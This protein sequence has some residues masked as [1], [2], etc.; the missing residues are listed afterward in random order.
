MATWVWFTRTKEQNVCVGD[1]DNVTSGDPLLP[2]RQTLY[3]CN[4]W[5]QVV[6]DALRILSDEAADVSSDRVEVPQQNCIPV[7]CRHKKV[8]NTTAMISLSYLYIC[9]SISLMKPLRPGKI[10]KLHLKPLLQRTSC[11]TSCPLHSYLCTDLIGLALVADHLL[12]EELGLAVGVGAAAHRV[13]LVDGQPLGVSI[14]RGRAAEH[15][16]VHSVSLHDLG[17]RPT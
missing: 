13:L 9:V 3:L 16:V 17:N 6:G 11:I 2:G 10:I 7:L 5:E 4:V 8:F 15:Q 1:N 12:D 14:H